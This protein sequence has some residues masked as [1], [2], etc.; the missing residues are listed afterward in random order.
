MPES[1]GPPPG[2]LHYFATTHWSVVL[3][4]GRAE[5]AEAAGAL[6]KLC[7]AYWHPIYHAVRRQGHDVEAAQDLTQDFFARLLAKE[8]LKLADP[9]RGR[10]RTFLLSAL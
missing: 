6:E 8:Y 4:A 3:T 9:A 1:E 5:A 7:R 2:D 10:F